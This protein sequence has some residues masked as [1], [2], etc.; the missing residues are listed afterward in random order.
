[1]D[2]ARPYFPKKR[3]LTRHK[4]ILTLQRTQ[5]ELESIIAIFFDLTEREKQPRDW[6]SEK[7]ADHVIG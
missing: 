7:T 2:A 6:L 5:K 4:K 3:F 1:M